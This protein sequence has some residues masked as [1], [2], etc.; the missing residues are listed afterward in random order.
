MPRNP[1]VF[2]EGVSHPLYRYLCQ[3]SHFLAVHHASQYDFNPLGTLPYHASR[4]SIHRF[5]T[6]L[7]SRT[8]SAPHHSTSELLRFL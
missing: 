1:W 2:G 5:G 6:L 4:G 3:H 7:E 8:F